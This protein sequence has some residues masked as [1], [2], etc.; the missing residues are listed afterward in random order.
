[1]PP[2]PLL[3]VPSLLTGLPAPACRAEALIGFRAPVLGH[4]GP[5]T[6]RVGPPGALTQGT[7]RMYSV[8]NI[9][10]FFVTSA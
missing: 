10:D 6:R 7:A 9:N 8:G 1:M 3:R 5:C 4:L 2:F